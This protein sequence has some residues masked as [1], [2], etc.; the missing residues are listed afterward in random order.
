MIDLN[1]T[2]ALGD[3]I[4]D[5]IDAAMASAHA[6]EPARD[7]L[8]ASILGDACERAIQY[9]HMRVPVDPGKGF[10]PRVLRCFDRGRWAEDYAIAL[11]KRAGFVLLDKD[12][13]TDKQWEFSLLDGRV[14][15]HPDGIFALWRGDGPSPITMPAMWECKCLN[16]K[17]WGKSKR[18]K[19]R[20]AHPRYFGQM[21][22]CM[23]ELNLSRGL[24][25]ALNADT[26][27]MHHELV[28][29]EPQ[30][31]QDLL[32]RASRILLAS[33]AGEMLPRGLAD[34]SRYECKYCDWAERCWA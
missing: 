32:A 20:V 23:G 5:R 15:G 34:P 28:T 17:S 1:S 21:Q 4:N 29:Y 24:F 26:M 27:E 31:H 10:P 18:D 13:A 2:S 3:R 19:L 30:A 12:V 25:T 7:Y 14:K 9:R 6:A 22:L 8:G 16:S 11:L 33:D